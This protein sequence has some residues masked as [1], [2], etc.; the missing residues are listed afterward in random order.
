VNPALSRS[1]ESVG[2]NGTPA[3]FARSMPRCRRLALIKPKS[4]KGDAQSGSGGFDAFE[5]DNYPSK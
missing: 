2:D 3:A 1:L 4:G 5:D